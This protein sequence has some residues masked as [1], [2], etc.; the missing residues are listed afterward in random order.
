MKEDFFVVVH[1]FVCMAFN[2]DRT[3]KMFR[4]FVYKDREYQERNKLKHYKEIRKK[5]AQKHGIKQSE[6][7]FLIWAYDLKFFTIRHAA[8]E[9]N[10]TERSIGNNIIM[11]LARKKYTYKY[12]DKLT[13]S[14]YEEYLFREET[15][16]NY[17]VRYAITQKARQ[18]VEDVYAELDI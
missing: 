17:R 3:E 1:K 18:V 5:V 7:E 6:L 12:I 14:R 8:K 4:E 2:K 13:P 15:K 10:M 11:Y 9:L 16:Y